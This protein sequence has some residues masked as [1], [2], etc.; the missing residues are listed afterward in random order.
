MTEVATTY[1]EFKPEIEK[2]W[3][4][5]FLD[6]EGKPKGQWSPYPE[7]TVGIVNDVKVNLTKTYKNIFNLNEFEV[8]VYA[9]FPS[10]YSHYTDADTRGIPP[11]Y[12][13]EFENRPKDKVLVNYCFNKSG[14]DYKTEISAVLEKVKQIFAAREDGLFRNG[15]AATIS[16]DSK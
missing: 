6:K 14:N 12:L 3:M 7:Q 1:I 10:A 16:L 4:A 11:M 15:G 13:E 5:S 2:K 8:C 9:F